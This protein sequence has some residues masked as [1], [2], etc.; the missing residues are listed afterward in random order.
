ML[1]EYDWTIIYLVQFHFV[2]EPINK[3]THLTLFIYSNLNSTAEVFFLIKC[4]LMN[5]KYLFSVGF[6]TSLMVQWFSVW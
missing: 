5:L 6:K 1:M 2:L 3:N 4:K